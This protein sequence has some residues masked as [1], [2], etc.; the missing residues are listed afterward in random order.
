MFFFARMPNSNFFKRDRNGYS[1]YGPVVLCCVVLMPNVGFGQIF[2]GDGTAL[3]ILGA[4]GQAM[5]PQGQQQNG[6][7]NGN[8]FNNNG[9]HTVLKPGSYQAQGNGTY[10]NATDNSFDLHS[11]PGRA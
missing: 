11:E 9:R 10:R 3:R 8:N 7:N 4:V 5:N 6:F 1:N 2:S